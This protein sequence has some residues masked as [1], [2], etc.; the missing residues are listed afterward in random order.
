MAIGSRSRS[1]PKKWRLCN[2]VCNLYS[3]SSFSTTDLQTL[4][5]ICN[6][7][8]CSATS[9][10]ALQPLHLLHN[11]SN[12]SA[13]SPAVVQPVQLLFN[14]YSLSAISPTALHSLQLL[15]ILSS[16]SAFSPAALQ[17]LQ[18]ISNL[19]NRSAILN[20]NPTLT[21]LIYIFFYSYC[22]AIS[23][24]CLAIFY[25]K[26]I[27]NLSCIFAISCAA[28]SISFSTL[29]SLQLVC[30]IPNFMHYFLVSYSYLPTHYHQS[31]LPLRNR[32]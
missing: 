14:L 20:S 13:T 21:D 27:L 17:P 22:S 30:N 10:A 6:L 26:V 16:C 32:F 11:L 18:L 4:Q 15:C 24:F 23:L 31:G 5:L 3:S 19:K 28:A 2:T 1:H 25:S 8:S 29:E 7:S 12:C 9:K